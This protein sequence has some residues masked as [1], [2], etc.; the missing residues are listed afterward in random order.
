M[1]KIFV[2][3]LI[4]LI[5]SCENTSVNHKVLNENNG[6]K[7][8]DMS[9]N[10]ILDIKLNDSGFIESILVNNGNVEIIM[11]FNKNTIESFLINDPMMKYYCQSNYDFGKKMLA[12]MEDY[13]EVSR[14]EEIYAT[15]EI[16]SSKRE[17]IRNNNP[18]GFL[19]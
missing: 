16:I 12:R 17:G 18:D 11:F 15:G 19:K 13:F 9:N 7:V 5:N 2:F 1:K 4:I 8:F 10:E 6:F 3:A 14:F